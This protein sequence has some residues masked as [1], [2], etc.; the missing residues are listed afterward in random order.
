MR[1]K[2]IEKPEEI[3]KK[4]KKTRRA[5]KETSSKVSVSFNLVE[6]IVIT[7]MTAIVVSVCSG[8]IVYNNYDSIVKKYDG[9]SNGTLSEFISTY[10]HILESYVEKIDE[11][12]LIDN[13]IKGM[14]DYLEDAHTSYLD[15]Q[16]TI[17]LEDKLKGT[18]KGVGV[19]MT[20]I[21]K[22]TYI[23]GI[24]ENSPAYEAGLKAGDQIISINGIDVEGKGASY[25]SSIIKNKTD[26]FEI[27]IKREEE[28]KTFSIE[29]SKIEIPSV[30]SEKIDNIG[31]LKIDTFSLNTYEQFKTKLEALEK[32][33]I[34]SLVIDVRG[35][36]GGYLSSAYEI[37]DL[38]IEKGKI[39]YQLKDKDGNI[40]AF[41]AKRSF[42]RNYKISVLM[43]EGSAS[44]SEILAAALQDS[45]GASL[46]GTKSFGKGTVQETE[47]LTSGSMIKYTTA[48]WLTPY[49]VCID[50]IGLMPTKEV[51]QNYETEVDEQL[52]AALELLK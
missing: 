50:G 30:T 14:F 16:D 52:E 38:F 35:N 13:A 41:N 37:A 24:F 2:N 49:G 21:N 27:T 33:K 6:V 11:K 48:H 39:I 51:V 10:D 15:E 23:V 22:G 47:K 43:N 9:S 46:I 42:K 28:T 5:K 4:V 26:R 17:T 18:Y 3:V 25:I 12:K 29:T 7:V 1:K 32:E 36:T 45:Y 44:A 31:Y 20:D 34:T 8:V 19:E 40:E